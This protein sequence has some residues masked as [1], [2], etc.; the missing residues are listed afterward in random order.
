MIIPFGFDFH[1]LSSV[2][3]YAC[4]F[5]AVPDGSRPPRVDFPRRSA[6]RFG[7]DSQR[8]KARYSIRRFSRVLAGLLAGYAIMLLL[9]FFFA[10]RVIFV[11]H[12]SSYRDAAWTIKLPAGDGVEISAVYLP[13]PAARYTVL[14]SHGNAEDLGDDMDFLGD[15]RAHG[16]SVFAYDYHGYGTSGGRPSERNA[17]RDVDAAYGYLSGRLGISPGRIIDHGRSLGGGVAVDLASR[18]KLAGLILESTFVSTFHVPSRFNFAPFDEFASIDKISAVHCPV[19]V[20]HGK[21]DN[22]IHLWHAEAL[23]QKAN[24]PKRFWWVEG[25]GHND[26]WDVAGEKYWQ[27]IQS[28]AQSLGR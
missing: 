2:T 8:Q 15:Y 28:F 11:P 14:F 22:M 10:D 9:A 12:P 19:L 17:Y 27:T 1:N 24:Q 5:G 18:R 13:N 21:K 16:F 20:I 7:I 6:I 26:C 3:V 25:A 23:F 4:D